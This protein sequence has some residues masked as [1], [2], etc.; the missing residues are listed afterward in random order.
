M[1]YKVKTKQKCFIDW[2]CI[3]M[4]NTTLINKLQLS[5]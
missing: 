4:P 5:F 1:G 3:T 2:G